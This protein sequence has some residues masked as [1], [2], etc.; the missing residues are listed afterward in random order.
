M[1][2]IALGICALLG[3]K[4]Q[5]TFIPVENRHS[6]DVFSLKRRSFWTAICHGSS[7]LLFLSPQSDGRFGGN[8]TD[9][10][11]LFDSLCRKH[12]RNVD[13]E[14]LF[15]SM[16]EGLKDRIFGEALIELVFVYFMQVDLSFGTNTNNLA[17]SMSANANLLAIHVFVR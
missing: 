5:G 6:L 4:L 9:L 1:L 13:V 3:T 15:Y 2:G 8:S 10:S 14:E 12:P 16:K 7:R 11:I 17:I